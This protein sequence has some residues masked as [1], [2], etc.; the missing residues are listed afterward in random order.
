M[1][2]QEQLNAARLDEA[3]YLF[4][5]ARSHFNRADQVL[6][7]GATGVAAAIGIAASQEKFAADV[8]IG[9]PPLL[10]LLLTYVL[11]AYGDVIVM[12]TARA[13]IEQELAR[14]MRQSP[15]IYQ[16]WANRR[17]R[18]TRTLGVP[19]LS[20]VVVLGLVALA[21][22]GAF[23]AWDIDG[24]AGE[25]AYVAVTLA[26]LATTVLSGIDYAMAERVTRENLCEWPAVN[27]PKPN[28]AGMRKVERRIAE[29]LA[30]PCETAD[31][32]PPAA[33]E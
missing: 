14:E 18:R 28:Y 13:R 1:S 27:P 25:L 8:L 24:L 31:C 33:R 20:L 17:Q 5:S 23:A 32:E 11:Q 6:G 7:I 26:L 30:G 2:D 9:V 3:Q 21:V 10:L 16:R 19:A 22:V 12:E 29:L 15:L 4:V